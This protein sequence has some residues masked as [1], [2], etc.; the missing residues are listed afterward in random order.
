[1]RLKPKYQRKQWSQ[2]DVKLN[3]AAR[4]WFIGPSCIL[5]YGYSYLNKGLEP[6]FHTR[7]NT[8]NQHYKQ[9]KSLNN[10]FVY[11]SPSF[12]DI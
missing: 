2:V 11:S 1:M 3:S 5:P 9:R 6:R 10:V 4:D 12:H 7:I 8:F